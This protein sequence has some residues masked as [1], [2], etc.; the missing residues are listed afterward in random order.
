MAIDYQL[1]V[2]NTAGEQI[3]VFAGSGRGM[4]GLLSFS[5][6]RELKYGGEWK[7]ELDANNKKVT[8]LELDPDTGERIDYIF[9]FWRRDYTFFAFGV[10]VIDTGWYRD[11]A[12]FHRADQFTLSGEGKNIYVARGVGLNSLLETEIVAW[13][14]GSAEAQKDGAAETVAKEYVDENIGPGAT[15][16]AGRRYA[17][18]LTGLTVQG[19]ALTGAN[20]SNDVADANLLDVLSDIARV[21]PADFMIVPTSEANDAFT[22]Q[23]QWKAN[24]WGLDRTEGNGV[25]DPVVWADEQG[26]IQNVRYIYSR[27]DEINTAS[28]GGPGKADTRLYTERTSG[29]ETDSPWARRVVFRAANKANLLTERETKGD[30]ILENGRARRSIAFDAKQTYYPRYGTSWDLGDLV[31][32]KFRGNDFTQ[33][34]VAVQVSY[35]STGDETIT[36]IMEDL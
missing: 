4:G 11:F 9:E 30:E 27:M 17:G 16:V 32:V 6:R 13:D 36:P 20:W 19:D 18:T 21:A 25:N 7:A 35:S 29:S 14:T 2:R 31:T 8:E 24:Q 15:V 33:K 34:I 26:N 1:R 5:Y 23:F 12:G 28:I 22:M 3:A 10:A